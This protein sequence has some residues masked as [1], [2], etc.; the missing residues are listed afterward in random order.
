MSYKSTVVNFLNFLLIQDKKSSFHHLLGKP[1]VIVWFEQY[2]VI[3]CPCF[4]YHPH[5]IETVWKFLTTI[6]L[7]P[8]A[9]NFDVTI[10]RIFELI[11]LVK[12]CLFIKVSVVPKDTYADVMTVIFCRLPWFHFTSHSL[13]SF[14]GGFETFFYF[15]KTIWIYV[16]SGQIELFVK[17]R[18]DR[19]FC[20]DF[21][22]KHPAESIHHILQEVWQHAWFNIQ[23]IILE[24]L[25]PFFKS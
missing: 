14:C 7:V 11:S 12:Y 20:K 21:G 13:Y 4:E 18:E 25:F 5:G 1:Y 22:A 3:C 17:G 24:M 2:T 23:I 6:G 10:L 16:W 8:N 19:D 9:Q 15:N